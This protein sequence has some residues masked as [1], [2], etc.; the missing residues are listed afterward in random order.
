M[1]FIIE[2]P[3]T[4]IKVLLTA[5]AALEGVEGMVSTPVG[6]R[7]A[8]AS[9]QQQPPTGVPQPHQA[10]AGVS[11]A[12]ARHAPHRSSSQA[13]Q[14]VTSEPLSG[15]A[16]GNSPA[17]VGSRM[18]TQQGAGRKSVQFAPS[19]M[20]SGGKDVSGKRPRQS[21]EV[22]VGQASMQAP[23]PATGW[24]GQ[25]PVDATGVDGSSGAANAPSGSA[26]KATGSK[27]QAKRAKSRPSFVE[28]F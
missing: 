25:V 9:A 4:D 1:P 24:K 19:E 22:A 13:Q 23:G 17:V 8:A 5:F 3:M 6:G 11:P 7:T 21:D 26:Q 2:Q 10:S 27:L 15:D 12:T 14:G 28:G 20:V 18:R 16:E